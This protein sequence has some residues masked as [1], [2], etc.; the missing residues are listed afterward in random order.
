M[1]TG[2]VVTNAGLTELAKLACGAAAD[3]FTYVA[4]GTGGDTPAAGD[5]ALQTEITTNGGGRVVADKHAYE[6]DYKA[7]FVEE[8]TFSGSLA[9]LE[10]GVLNA[11]SSGDL[12]MRH[13]F[14]YTI[15][16]VSTDTLT[17]TITATF[18]DTTA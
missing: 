11:A 17:L 1:A 12:L 14:A 13:V 15:N 8:F 18:S 16:V 4:R 9:I 3:A 5:T 10:C 6:A 2:T 7:K